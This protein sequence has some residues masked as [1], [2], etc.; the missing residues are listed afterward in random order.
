[1]PRIT[2]RTALKTGTALALSPLA[3]NMCATRSLAAEPYAD[4]VLVDGEPPKPERGSFTVA[5]LPDTQNYSERYPATYLAQTNWIVENQQARNIAAVLHLGDI[6]NNNAPAEWDNAV[7]AM[8][9]LDGKLPYAMVPGNHDYSAG[10]RCQDRTTLI[11]DYFSVGQYKGTPSFGGTYD[12]EPERLENSYHLFSA[13]GRN[14]LVVALEFGPRR[15]VVR[16][17]NEVVAK[18]KDRA[19][20][21]ITHAYMYDDDTRYDWQKYGEKQTWNPH[22]YG[23][24]KATADDVCDGEQLWNLLVSKHENFLLTLNGHVLHDGLGRTVTATPG[25]RDVNQVLV[26]FQMR[27]KGGDGWLRLVEFRADGRTAQV[28]DYSPTR[29]QR[30]ESPQNQFAMKLSPPAQA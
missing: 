18:H 26:N 20:I 28:Y 3:I 11:N 2:R 10:G 14:F 4:A 15:D 19:A 17:A 27:P 23:V 30:N 5:V 29:N 22:N 1:M 8:R 25:G 7:K 16:W 21:L 24:A 9:V 13:E 6:T 12:K